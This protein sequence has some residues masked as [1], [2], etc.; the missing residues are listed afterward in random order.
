[1]SRKSIGL[2]VCTILIFLLVASA[3]AIE[4]KNANENFTNP[5]STVKSINSSSFGSFALADSD[6][7]VSRQKYAEF[8]ERSNPSPDVKTGIKL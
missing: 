6:A 8:G 4:N 5:D 1:M 7:D 2:L 3:M